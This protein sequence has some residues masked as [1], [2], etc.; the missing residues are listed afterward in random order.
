MSEKD[1]FYD[2]LMRFLFIPYKWG[3]S[4]PLEGLDCS[5]FVQLALDFLSIDP[6]GDQSADALYRHFMLYGDRTAKADLGT[7]L[8]FGSMNKITHV[9]IALDSQKMIEAGSGDSSIVNLET[10]RQKGAFI[11]VSRISRRKDLVE[12]LRPRGIGW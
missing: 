6:P 4:H 3:G 11:K 1:Q 8:F 2:Y 9:G 7:L 5:G 10:A 12:M